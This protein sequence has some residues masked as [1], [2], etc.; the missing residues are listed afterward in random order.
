M[1]VDSHAHLEMTQF[2]GDRAQVLERARGAG[3]ETIVAIGSGTG[4]GSLACGI[5]LAEQHDWIL[6]TIGIH[7]HE[8]NLAMDSDFEEMERLA[9]HPKVIAWGEIGLDYFYDHSPRE[10][11]RAVFVR[12]MELAGAAKLPI[13]IHCRPSEG[14]DNAWQDCLQ[15]LR[16]HWAPGL[17]G[18]LHCFT[19]QLEHMRA[20]L[21]M[22]FII[23]FAGNVTFAKAQNIR[24][25][26]REAPLDRMFIETDSPFLAPVPHRGKR[27]EPAF[28]VE[29]ARQIAE[30]RGLS[31]EQVGERTSRNFYDFF[32]LHSSNSS[33]TR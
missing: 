11:Q 30:L 32:K 14:S 29:V 5:E 18:V 26:A 9:G 24:D 21:D 33:S 22:G 1:F 3:L 12:Q 31:R 28:V 13:V 19:G 8:A 17:G 15:L 25:A 20:A 2:D 16:E 27:N 10:V 7:P 4:P 23:S 6:A